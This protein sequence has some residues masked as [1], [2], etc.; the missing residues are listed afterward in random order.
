M[1]CRIRTVSLLTLLLTVAACGGGGGT[2][3]PDIEG[4][5][6]VSI[7]PSSPSVAVGGTI[8]LTATPRNVDGI[9]LTGKS[10]TWSSSALGVATVSPSGLVT[11]VA[12]GNATLTA[13]SEGKSGT[14]QV[15]VT[16]AP[17]AA[18]ATVT[19]SGGAASIV[20]GATTT[21]TATLRD[22]ANNVLIGRT[23]TWLSSNTTLATVSATGVVTGVTAGGPVTITA[24]SEGKNATAQLTV[25]APPPAPVATVTL[26]GGAATIAVGATTTF[27]A[28]LRDAADNILTGR[29]VTWGSS[30]T[31]V[32]TVSAA[33][34]VTGVSG[35]G[36]VTITAT[37]EGVNATA[38]VTV[39]SPP[40]TLT[41]D[42]FGAESYH[43][44]QL[45]GIAGPIVYCHGEG[46]FGQLGRNAVVATQLSPLQLIGPFAFTKVYAGNFFTC[47]L[48]AAGAAWCWGF[49]AQGS[50]GYGGNAH[51]LAP[52]AVA[53]GRSFTRLFL[54]WGGTACGLEASGAAWCWGNGGFG[55][56]GNGLLT[57]SWIPV[58][59]APGM[60]FTSMAVTA[61]TTCGLTSVGAA[62]CWGWN[63]EGATGNG[64]TT[65][66]QLTPMPVSGGHQFVEI[67]GG[68]FSFCGRKA[69]G[70]VFCW[71]AEWEPDEGGTPS[72]RS[73]PVRLADVTIRSTP[74]QIV[75]EQRFVRLGGGTG[76]MCGLTAAGAAWCWGAIMGYVKTPQPVPGGLV[77]SEIDVGTEHAC[78]RVG[79]E[80]YC[81]GKNNSG[82]LGDGTT[83]NRTIPVRATIFH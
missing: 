68:Y 74:V 41:M 65:G 19:L 44:C 75:T 60:T 38:Q 52:V 15:T 62:W 53:G 34:V 66:Y 39:T 26:S 32:A 1:A 2:T 50:T 9:S 21:F 24:T 57:N 79:E 4:V 17:P 69:D 70:T 73:A 77:F 14:T 81:W 46:T 55:A 5:A 6:S 23:V 64:S 33:G 11:A 12:P 76:G 54:G 82:Q 25:T 56:L 18:V 37:S 43:T 22:A 83:T 72:L 49:G 36:P 48:T 80:I 7:S 13:T 31:T 42:T 63:E 58:A 45:G 67:A 71:G 29:T 28:T 10:V 8:Q 51:Q 30:N 59:A 35:G 61:W 47:A 78:G 3:G 16:A 20:A 40:V 27:A